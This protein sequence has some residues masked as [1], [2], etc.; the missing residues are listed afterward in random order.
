MKKLT[1]GARLNRREARA[2]LAQKDAELVKAQQTIRN[3]DIVIGQKNDIVN[4]ALAQSS[5][6]R[7][8]FRA[9]ASLVAR[10]SILA[11]E[12]TTMSHSN[13][14][15]RKHGDRIETIPVEPMR[16]FD[17][18]DLPMDDCYLTRE[19]LRLLCVEKVADRMRGLVHARVELTNREVVYTISEKTLRTMS[20]REL[21][22]YLIPEIASKLAEKLAGEIKKDY[23]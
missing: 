5:E 13:P 10:Q 9:I 11:G 17:I 21:T 4:S 3:K 19:V 14:W 6:Y 7:D 20:H 2:A 15:D 8:R 16:S 12:P 22:T 18:S 1:T 23:R